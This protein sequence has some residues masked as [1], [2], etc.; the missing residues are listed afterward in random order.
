[1]ILFQMFDNIFD[2][3]MKL[4]ELIRILIFIDG[5][6]ID[7]FVLNDVLIVYLNLVV[8]FCCNFRFEIWCFLYLNIRSIFLFD[9]GIQNMLLLNIFDVGCIRLNIEI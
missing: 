6:R 4:V 3:S 1:M 7:V 8:I 2:G 9:K 5:V